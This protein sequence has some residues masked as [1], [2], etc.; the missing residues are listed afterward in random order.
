MTIRSCKN[1]FSPSVIIIMLAVLV[2]VGGGLFWFFN[3][4]ERKEFLRS[5]GMSPAAYNN[6]YLAAER[7]FTRSGKEAES[8]RGLNLLANLP[9][10]HDAIFI[11]RLPGGL[12]QSVG[13]SIFDWVRDG[14]HLLMMPNMLDNKN[15]N[16]PDFSRR[17]GVRYAP[18]PEESSDCGCPDEGDNSV[19]TNEEDTPEETATTEDAEDY[20]EYHPYDQVLELALGEHRIQLESN[21]Y[22]YLEDVAGTAVYTIDASYIKRYTNNDDKNR[23][24]HNT[25][26]KQNNH[27]LLQ[28]QVGDGKITVFSDTDLFTNDLIGNRD[29]AFFL[30]HLIKDSDK[31]WL[32]Y[33]SNVDSLVEII[34]R[35]A[36]FFWVSL[37]ITLFII[38]WMCQMRSGPL[39]TRKEGH[40]QSILTHIDATGNYFWRNDGCSNIVNTNRKYIMQRWQLSRQGG[41]TE[42]EILS[43]DLLHLAE[44]TGINPEEVTTA[45]QLKHRT[46]QDFIRSS[47]ALQK[48]SLTLQGGEK[49]RN[50]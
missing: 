28:Y 35:Q 3:N 15:P 44:K 26:I 30:A 39:M 2:I 18:Y 11:A 31:V 29:H 37:L 41:Q 14:G 38:G 23:S 33:S 47:Q 43:A 27:W 12:A 4:F 50:D 8:V 45:F 22:R 13:D 17:V 42:S 5:S 36:P 1:I 21:A 34:W 16:A 7:F 49:K 19:P 9:S 48:F 24:D 46:E 10:S 32:I 20:Y 25:L 40:P 6:S